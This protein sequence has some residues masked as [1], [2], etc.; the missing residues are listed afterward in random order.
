MYVSNLHD[1]MYAVIFVWD[2]GFVHIFSAF[3]VWWVR[4]H[5]GVWGVGGVGMEGSNRFV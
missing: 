2:G 1:F 3:M 5:A 4:R